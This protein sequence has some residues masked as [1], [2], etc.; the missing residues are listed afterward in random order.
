[1]IDG[2]EHYDDLLMRIASLGFAHGPRYGASL[3]IRRPGPSHSRVGG[4]NGLGHLRPRAA[5]VLRPQGPL[6]SGP[7]VWRHPRLPGGGHRRVFCQTCR[8]V[9]QEQ[10]TWLA[11]SPLYTKRFAF[12]VGRRCRASPIRDVARELVL[13]WKTVKALDTQYMREQ[14][15]RTGTPG[16][17]IIGIDEVSIKKGHTYRIVVSRLVRRRAIWFGGKDRSEA[18]MDGFYQWLGP[19]KSHK[20]RLAVMDM[21]PA[22]RT[23]TLKPEHAP[24][25]AI[26]S[27]R[28]VPRHAPPGGGP[29][30]G[31][32]A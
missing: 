22:F 20:I 15:R 17:R 7:A 1:M 12:F 23:A 19:K 25:A 13:D 27:V 21:W 4:K 30:H 3:V 28:Q 9:K 18:S 29:R 31:P 32:Q 5:G 11:H 14:L 2:C 26:L 10:L 8:S 24:Q 16:P 6:D